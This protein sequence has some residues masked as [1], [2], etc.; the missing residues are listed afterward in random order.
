MSPFSSSW[1]TCSTNRSCRLGK[2]S[3]IVRFLTSNINTS[4]IQST[5][6]IVSHSRRSRLHVEWFPASFRI[7]TSL[8]SS[9]F[10][11][12]A[13]R[14]FFSYMI[15]SQSIDLRF[16]RWLMILCFLFSAPVAIAGAFFLIDMPWKARPNWI[17]SDSVSRSTLISLGDAD[18]SLNSVQDLKLANL[19]LAKEGR[20]PAA[21]ITREKVRVLFQSHQCFSPLRLMILAHV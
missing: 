16:S 20:A 21:R 8:W 4:L 10:G 3:V 5:L 15:P 7:H 18:A 17:F 1:D 2:R 13:V 19:R 12:M 14:L 11:G 6:T 9:R